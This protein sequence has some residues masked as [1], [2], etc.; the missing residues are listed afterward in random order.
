MTRNTCVGSMLNQ[1][2]ALLWHTGWVCFWPNTSLKFSS[3]QFRSSFVETVL[4]S[5]SHC[6]DSKSLSRS[7]IIDSR[8]ILICAVLSRAILNTADTFS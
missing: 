3:V 1:G 4:T 2:Q 6:E 7:G 5:M 8:K